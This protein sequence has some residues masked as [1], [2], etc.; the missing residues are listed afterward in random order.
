M[1][2][3]WKEK[4]RHPRFR[5]YCPISFIS[6]DKLRLGE[7]ADLSL[8]GMRIHCRTILLKGETYEFTVVMNGHAI[9]PKGKIVYIQSQP[10]FTYGAG[11]S[12]LPLSEEHENRLNGF[13]SAQNP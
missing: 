3:P 13:L 6:F 1:I 8:G 2:Q 5:V 10:E 7:T 4:R 11:V 12:F 9:S